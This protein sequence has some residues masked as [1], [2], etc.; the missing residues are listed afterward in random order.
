MK[1]TKSQKKLMASVIMRRM[2]AWKIKIRKLDTLQHRW[3]DEGWK[4]VYS[5]G[6][7]VYE[8]DKDTP[9]GTFKDVPDWWYFFHDWNTKLFPNM[10]RQVYDM[11]PITQ[12][13]DIKLN[14]AHPWVKEVL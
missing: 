11:V 10:E 1:F 12:P 6:V 8:E 14:R 4:I 3:I 13:Q 2:F 7:N 5:E 9:Y